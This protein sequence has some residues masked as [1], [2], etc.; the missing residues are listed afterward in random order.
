MQ[1]AWRMAPVEPCRDLGLT[2]RQSKPRDFPKCTVFHGVGK[3]R[4]VGR[5]E[6]Y[7]SMLT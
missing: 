6:S 4:P 7:V 3:R 1:M 5:G 2:P